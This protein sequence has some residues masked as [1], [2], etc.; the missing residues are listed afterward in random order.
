MAKSK[1]FTMRIKDSL[2]VSTLFKQ[3][4]NALYYF[5]A[6]ALGIAPSKNEFVYNPKSGLFSN[7]CLSK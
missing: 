1:G 7:A 3:H 4:K 5:S 6:E 2:R